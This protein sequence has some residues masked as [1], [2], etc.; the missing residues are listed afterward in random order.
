MKHRTDQERD[1]LPTLLAITDSPP[2]KLP[3]MI[4]LSVLALVAILLLWSVLGRLDVVATAEGRLVPQSKLKIVQPADAGIV[5]EIL[6]REGELVEA[7]QVMMRLD[8]QILEA[9]RHTVGSEHAQ[10]RLQLRRIDAELAGVSIHRE[11][12]DPPELFLQVSLQGQAHR[13]AYLDAVAS[14]RAMSDKVSHD[15]QAAGELLTKLESTLPIARRSADAYTK[16]QRDGFISAIAGDDKQREF[17]EKSQDLRA[18]QAT[19]ASLR[20]MLANSHRKLAQ[21]SSMYRS[22]LL[23]ERASTDAQ[24]RRLS[25]EKVK[26]EH[27]NGWLQL[28]APQAGIVKDLST[29]TIGTV[30]APGT[31][32]MSLVPLNEPLRAEVMLK[33]EDAGFVHLG[34]RVKLKF[35]AYP[36]QKYGM[37]DGEIDHIGPD[38]SDPQT[39]SRDGLD[40]AQTFA[41]YPVWVK[42]SRQTLVLD[43]KILALTPGMQLV[44]DIHQGQRSVLEYLLSPIQRAWMEAARER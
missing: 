16:L 9:D 6:V 32:L 23:A 35:A 33:N 43:K 28:R 18:Q 4:L 21:L 17:L 15:L 25:G 13:Q 10:L 19:V 24:L 14:E 20:D 41:R 30:V 8:P 31:V 40:P 39:G 38:V 5:T 7:G 1:F 11:P 34:Q 42:L 44:A 27:K 37:I 2:P 29:H 26:L 3:R 36:F 22:D 12:D